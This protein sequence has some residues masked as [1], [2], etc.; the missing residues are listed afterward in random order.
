MPKKIQILD[1]IPSLA[2][3]PIFYCSTH[4]AYYFSEPGKPTLATEFT[5]PPNTIIIETTP[6]QYL[7]YFVNLLD[8]ISPLLINRR[9]FLKYLDG[10][11]SKANRATG[12]RHKIIEALSNF[13]VYLPG[14]RIVNRGLT[15][16]SGRLVKPNGRTQSERVVFKD[17]V[18]TKFY[19]ENKEPIQILKPVRDHLMANPFTSFETYETILAKLDEDPHG[20]PGQPRI[21]IFPSCGDVPEPEKYPAQIRHVEELQRISKLRWMSLQKR[22]LNAVMKDYTK[23]LPA[24]PQPAGGA[25][26]SASLYEGFAGERQENPLGHGEYNVAQSGLNQPVQEKSGPLLRSEIQKDPVAEAI[27]AL[28]TLPHGLKQ[29]FELQSIG[30]AGGGHI[31]YK[32][33]GNLTRAE[34]NARLQAGQVLYEFIHGDPTRLTIMHGGSSH[35]SRRKRRARAGKKTKRYSIFT[36]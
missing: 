34:I 29:V 10:Q 30:G 1:A 22:T 36:K 33:V 8:V 31:N 9:R 27:P 18:F 24:A 19:P 35:K 6:I 25:A 17:M 16:G 11:P 14:A 26:A 21:V 7:C 32:L 20:E 13:I 2:T 4:G 23:S 3:A 5:V 15:I 28:K 12:Q